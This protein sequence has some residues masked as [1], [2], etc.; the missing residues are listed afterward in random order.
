MN[1]T[2]IIAQL[3]ATNSKNE[4]AA[5]LEANKH[6]DTLKLVFQVAYSKTLNFFV[7]ALKVDN[8]ARGMRNLGE[9]IDLL[10][11]NV[12]G[13]KYTGD[14]A[15]KYM[16]A[17][18]NGCEEPETLM[19]VIN[20]DLECGIQTTLTNKVWKNLVMEP[21]YQSYK[22]FKEDLLRKFKFPAF[23]QDKQDGLYAD[24]LVWSDRIIYRSRSGKEL[25]F[26]ATDKVEKGLMIMALACGAFV[27]H[28]EG[29]VI[30]PT[31]RL[32]VM[33]REEGNGYLN[34]LPEEID[35]D[36]VKL[37]VWDKVTMAEYDARESKVPYDKRLSN[38][39]AVIDCV[40]GGVNL[41]LVNSRICQTMAEAIE[42]FIQARTDG[43][44]GTMW[45]Q[46]DMPWG[47]N[48]TSKGIKLKNEF[49]AEFIVVD[50][51][52]HK[53]KPGWIGALIVESREG[54]FRFGVGSG[55]ND[56]DRQQEP[57]AFL[58]K[59]LSIK[60][61]DV[62]TSDSK[63][64]YS[65]FLPRYLEIRNDKTEANTFEEVMEARDSLIATMKIIAGLV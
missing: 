42:H 47:D 56:K 11:E 39:G 49:D 21:P 65:L 44:E 41:E 62:T 37:V 35:R 50:T 33:S 45:K 52:P 26:R 34:Q 55:L 31:S 60:G 8:P 6:N 51:V 61:N 4:K 28:G 19:K 27:L 30:D 13:R 7:R 46:I 36:L 43:K 64:T 53:K 20:R 57:E 2:Q 3:A 29:L 54:K 16:I 59:I 17:L 5:I 38:V 48:K 24:I 22:L 9:S 32:G 10:V 58:Q 40:K 25:N 63:D 15:K 1:S 23:C 14:E 12:A 18:I